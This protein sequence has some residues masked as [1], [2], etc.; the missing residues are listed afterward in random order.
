M[1]LRLKDAVLILESNLSGYGYSAI[2][3]LK[4]MG[5]HTIFLS[6]DVGEYRNSVT[7]PTDV[8]D[9]VAL[10]D[11]YDIG[12]I[13]DFAYGSERKIVAC[14][15]FDDFRVLQSSIVNRY[16]GN[17]AHP[18]VPALL[19]CR[20]KSVLRKKL[21]GSRYEL[22]HIVFNEANAM[23]AIDEPPFGFPCVVKPVDENGS[24]AVRVCYSATD[25][26]EAVGDILA[27]PAVNSR[28]YSSSRK[29]IVEEYVGGD[30][31]SAEMV[32]DP[33]GGVWRILG[34]TKKFITPPPRCVELAHIYPHQ[35]DAE[36][37]REISGGLLAVMSAIDLRSTFA[38]VEFKVDGGRFHVIE[39]NP[40]PG[41]DMI[42]ELMTL[43]RGYDPI[44]MMVCANMN[45]PLG[46]E[47]VPTRNGFA[48]I[49]FIT[50][51]EPGHVSGFTL[52]DNEFVRQKSF[53]LP[54]T[55]Q[56][57]RNSDDRLGYAVYMNQNHTYIRSKVAGFINRELFTVEREG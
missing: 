49:G 17:N 12:K 47:A 52:L 35:F 19:A 39:V 37:D 33:N 30:E 48:A 22:R 24:V 14:L 15:A 40:R 44:R 23:A 5:Y 28:G 27:L 56:G 31:F 42:A 10:V 8:A 21:S 2:Q 57:L 18:S 11:T 29:F 3:Y 16:L 45:L 20:F 54:R 9:E 25:M 51:E 26:R 55:I 34:I 46:D 4:E 43:A 7:N 13:L 36:L 38:H 1:E 50:E 53:G 6:R 41:G 32:W